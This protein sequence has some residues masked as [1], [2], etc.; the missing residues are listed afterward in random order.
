MAGKLPMFTK[1]TVIGI[2]L[3]GHEKDPITLQ[4]NEAK[5]LAEW[6]MLA[7]NA[8][9]G[10]TRTFLLNG[11]ELVHYTDSKFGFRFRHPND[12]Y[13]LIDV[14]EDIMLRGASGILSM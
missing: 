7:F 13:H 5:R 10:Q 3:P 11:H 8:R 6:I 9:D 1:V 4:L 12:L 14:K 2:E